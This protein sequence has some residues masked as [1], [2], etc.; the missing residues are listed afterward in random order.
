MNTV[1]LHKH[2]IACMSS[3]VLSSLLRDKITLYKQNINHIFFL[4]RGS[5][6]QNFN[7][8]GF[9]FQNNLT[10]CMVVLFDVHTC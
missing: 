7:I 1:K 3:S 6:K 10:T 4:K 5:Y 8:H 9:S 2:G